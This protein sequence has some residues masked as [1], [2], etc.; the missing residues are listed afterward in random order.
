VKVAKSNAAIP[1]VVYRVSELVAYIVRDIGIGTNLAMAPRRAT[2]W[3]VLM[4]PQ[5][6]TLTVMSG[7]LLESRGALIPALSAGGLDKQTTLRAWNG[8]A[9]GAWY[10][11][12]LLKRFNEAVKAEQKW[13]PLV[14]GGRNVKA[15][16]TMAPRRATFGIFRPRLKDCPG[17]HYDSQAG[18]ALPA[19]SFGILGAVGTVP[20]MDA[21]GKIDE[22]RVTLPLKIVRAEGRAAKS[23]EGLKVALL[24]AMGALVKKGADEITGKDILTGDRKFSAVKMLENGCT[25]MAPRRATLAIRRAANMTLLRSEPPPYKG[26]GPKPKLGEL[27]RPLPRQR[28]NK[29]IPASKPEGGPSRGHETE[30]WSEMHDGQQV[31]LTAEIWRNVIPK[32]QKDWTKRQRELVKKAT[33]TAVVVHHPAFNN[34]LVIL[35]TVPFT[36]QQGMAVRG[37]TRLVVR[38]RWGIEQPPLV[39]KQL[40]GGHRQFVHEPDMCYRFPE[41]IFV[42]GATVT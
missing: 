12:A 20:M 3:H 30:E 19:I 7:R 33:W 29:V 42:A 13:Q 15:Y 41:L 23:E 10:L 31:T 5:R 26:R 28:L 22:Q 35:M 32:P 11:D 1:Q 40:L 25:A 39:A 8:A 2:F 27:V 21:T 17:R 9:H 37:A 24:G 14:V 36:A 18:K 34:P 4:A 6:A 16:D 38:G